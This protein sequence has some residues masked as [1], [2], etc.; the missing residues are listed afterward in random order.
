MKIIT[1]KIITRLTVL[2]VAVTLVF[3][4]LS[5]LVVKAQA[6]P[7]VV[8]WDT[9]MVKL[10]QPNTG[11]NSDPIPADAAN[12]GA[13]TFSAARNE[14]EPF[15]IF[16]AAQ[17]AAVSQ[18]DVSI[19]DLADGAGNVIT[20]SQP[21]GKPKNVVVYREHYLNVTSKSNDIS[22]LGLT[23]DALIPRID[24]YYGEVRRVP[25]ENK[26]AFPFDVAANTKQGVW[27]DVYVP[28]GTPAGL[29]TGQVSV[30]IGG[31][32]FKQ[33]PVQLTVRNFELPSTPTLKTSYAVGTS[34]MTLGHFHQ[35]ISSLPE[36][37]GTTLLSLYTKE[38]LL[39]RLSNE[40]AIWPKPRWTGSTIDWTIPTPSA[41]NK[42]KERYPEF[43]SGA[44]N[45]PGGKLPGAKLT[46]VRL[47]EDKVFTGTTL[48]FA[49]QQYGSLAN[50]QT[51]MNLY[52]D[53]FKQNGWHSQLFYYLWDEPYYVPT[54]CDAQGNCVWRCDRNWNGA[55]STVWPDLYKKSKWFKD[56]GID[57]PVLLTTN[58]QAA[59]D[60][61][62]SAT[63]YDP[64]PPASFGAPVPP[65]VDPNWQRYT[66]NYVVANRQ[67]DGKPNGVDSPQD[68][69]R[70]PFNQ[71]LRSTYDPIITPPSKQLWW[72]HACGNHDCGGTGENEY[73]APMADLPNVYSRMFQWMTYRYQ[74]GYAAPGPDA[75]LYFETVYAYQNWDGVPNSPSDPWNRIYYFTGNG[76]GTFFYPGRP[77]RIGG[78]SHIPIPSI[79]VK[80]LRE[81]IEDFEY[82]KLVETSKNAEGMNGKQ[83]IYDNILLPYLG[84]LDPRDNTAKFITYVWNKNPGSPTAPNG[85]LRAREVLA[86][87]VTP[88]PDFAL[89]VSPFSAT[90][91][92]TEAATAAIAVTSINGFNLAV[93]L[94]CSSPNGTIACSLNPSS[95]TPASN[96]NATSILTLT[97][98]S[99]TPAGTYPIIITATSGALSYRATFNL[100]V[101]I[102][103]FALSVSPSSATVPPGEGATATVTVTSINR[104]SSATNLS[105]S[106]PVGTVA[107]SL[108]PVSVTPAGN[109]NASS[110]LTVTTQ[111]TTPGGNY[112]ITLTASS[113]A[114]THQATFDFNVQ[115][116]P[117]SSDT[118]TREDSSDLGTDWNETLPNLEVFSNQVR[119]VDTGDKEAIFLKSLGPDQDV[120]ADV[121]VTAAGNS[122]AVVARWADSNNFYRVRL[123]VGAGNIVL[124]KTV[125]SVT[126]QL[127]A[128]T[129]ALSY[130]TYYRV[131][132]VAQGT[133][134]SVYF[135]N[136]NAAAIVVSD[137]TLAAGNYAGIRSVA[138]AAATTWF[139][140]FAAVVPSE[141]TFN[142]TFDR[143]DSTAFGSAWNETLPDLVISSGQVRNVN[144][145]NKEAIFARAIGPDQDV[146][147]DTKLTAS[148]NSTAVVARWSDSNNFY[149]VRLDVGQGNLALFKTVAGV[150][151]RLGDL[152]S[153]PLSFNTYYRL[154]LVV[155]GSSLSVYFGSETT[156]AISLT[157]TALTTGNFA[158]IRLFAAAASTGFYDNFRV[159]FPFNDTF[160]RANSTALGASWNENLP[161]LEI[162]SNQLRNVN[163]GSKSA[164]FA[165]SIG[166]DQ[167]VS[168]D[169]K[170]MATGNMAAVVG[171]W[172]DANNFYYAS[173]DPGLGSVF[174]FKQVAGVATRLGE[175]PRPLSYN[176]YYRL[177]MDVLGSTLAVYF[178]GETAPAISVTD[179]ELTTGNYGGVR[180]FASAASTVLIDN[181]KLVRKADQT[182]SFDPLAGRTYGDPDFALSAT[183]TS[184]LPVSFSILSGPAVISGDTVHLTGIGIVTVRA[185]QVGN[186]NYNA[187]VD[188]TQSFQVAKADQ[189]IL[190]S[191]LPDKTYGDTPFTVSATGGGSDN[192]ITFSAS[193]SCT[194]SGP[195]GSTITITSAGSCAVTA[196]EAGN[197]NYNAAVDVSRSFT[198]DRATANIAVGYTGVYDGNAH[199]AIGSATGVNGE[200]LSEL[201]AL[202]APFT[203]VPGGT[204]H[205]TFTGNTNYAPASGDASILITARPIEVTANP[206]QTK[207]YGKADPATFS[208]S[209][210]GGSFVNGDGFSGALSRAA[211]ENAGSYAIN[212]NTLTAGGNYTLTYAGA[213]FKITQAAASITVN[214]YTGIYDGHAHGATGSAAGVN[215]EDVT[216]LLILG[217]SFTNVPGGTAHWVFAGNTN[218]VSASGD[219]VV[220][221]TKAT[222][223]VSWNAPADI[224]YGT[225]LSATQLNA[226]ANVPGT[227]SYTPVS[228]T[229]LNAGSSQ[230]LLVAF[231]P[232]DAINYNAASK[233][234]QINVLKAT[235]MFSNLSSPVII[236]G[237]AT[238]NLSGKISFGALIPTGSVA[239]TL[240]SVTQS[241]T[242]NATIQANGNFSSSFAT[243]TL[244]PANPYIITF[245]WAGNSNFNSVNGNSTLIV[246][247]GIVQLN[248]RTRVYWRGSTIP[249]RLQI[250]NASG[251]NLS[252]ANIP[253]T[254]IG[255]ALDSTNVSGPAEDAGDASPDDNFRFDRDSYSYNLR[256]NGLST[257]VYNL[258][259]KVGADPVVHSIQF[260]VR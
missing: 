246:S 39:H 226:V 205:W 36:E 24:E 100:V 168:A 32:I 186:N 19:T 181:F 55:R 109:Q 34:E 118:F 227:F 72:Y 137:T 188:V 144:T 257:G 199:G 112:P 102:P 127:G 184:G 99:A 149:R 254:A 232:A 134:L 193:G 11:A 75:E 48:D 242:Q 87:N 209:V 216:S 120:A 244:K 162:F 53:H 41:D 37:T 136:E 161:D 229:T 260:Q 140:N 56:N 206:G 183:A 150:T 234:V 211:G 197:S 233:N 115:S 62:T 77:D 88:Q 15:Q 241:V 248:D 121:K 235:P 192:P 23:P 31:T 142:D 166:P 202:G 249:I 78:T 122:A 175:A 221:I 42:S 54:N 204:A 131:R 259:F 171:R 16:V 33:I 201:L 79:R 258:Y 240:N 14:F 119:N 223:I 154:R 76:D 17:S 6:D 195:D 219:A 256:T 74:V 208:Y 169:C 66:D 110:I 207:V 58:R 71:N 3:S 61:I 151:T 253:V 49:A 135:G 106:S 250:T 128:A 198:V 73:I 12:R 185:S 224:V 81:G 114:L 90:V 93:N 113:G 51:Y 252:S 50:Y 187:A 46:T 176:T 57:V 190:F 170:V 237:T 2:L 80:M 91:M 179:T 212:Q 44:S 139:D 95:I 215:G 157:D 1:M 123:D 156:P 85:L 153:R 5:L 52:T 92:P 189:I 9:G 182:I 63:G 7:P 94:S 116:P 126:T 210:T 164:V 4:M 173:L 178:A 159:T 138:T 96:Q 155:K 167:V 69:T 172:S 225:A 214:G 200:D 239:I 251:H 146:T 38:L 21:D 194:S 247:Y 18:V 165:R 236:Y 47:R 28:T 67:M 82:L 163:A 222:P 101:Q 141:E 124:S 65:I 70:K 147:A 158:G 132:L 108:N 220:S 228:G 64:A 130:N 84:D 191:A 59:E 125:G 25:G 238:T 27:F 29:Y 230:P 196:S 68:S 97:T 8:W 111:P 103:D 217:A 86:K 98:Q 255:I 83:W 218:Y 40:L 129:R 245:S 213:S 160:D 13:V 152:A 45:L 243:A 89:S 43:L 104:F 203:N 177:R 30:T 231:T 26:P 117:Q 107:C 180:M 105:C 10:R 143:A 20:A 145:G 60:C 148:G 133:L 35:S 22:T 174:L